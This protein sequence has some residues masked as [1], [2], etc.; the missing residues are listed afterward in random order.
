ML[1]SE[2]DQFVA[3]TRALNFNSSNGDWEIE[4][5]GARAARVQEQNPAPNFR[6]WLMRVTADDRLEACRFRIEIEGLNLMDDVEKRGLDL[7][8]RG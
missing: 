8:D 6:R 5:S 1:N 4:S 3:Q 2:L 7:E